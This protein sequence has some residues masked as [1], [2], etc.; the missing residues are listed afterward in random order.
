[1]TYGREF[2]RGYRAIVT[3]GAQ[4]IGSEI[5]RELVAVGCR[6]A[7]IDLQGEKAEA[8]ALEL[9]DGCIGIS[10]DITVATESVAAVDQVRN[11]MGGIDILINTAAPGRNRGVIGKIADSDWA[12]HQSVVL[13]GAANMVEATLN[14]LTASK[15]GAIV[16]ISSVLAGSVGLDQASVAYHVAKAGLNQFTRWLAVRCGP[17][18]VRVNAV[19]PGLVDRGVGQK[20]SDSLINRTIIETLVPVGRAAS[21]QEV[22]KAV[23]FLAS[24]A[25]SYITG[26]VITVDGGMGL[27]ETFG[28]GLSVYN[29]FARP[30]DL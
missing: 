23:I 26:E 12:L 20:I 27:R 4:G 13:G 14:D 6:V 3:G 29:A 9:G 21:G 5:V 10:A 18:G 11:A 7:I 1:M 28:S 17:V 25:A 8:L 30:S 2:L 16:N 22:A 24:D 15:R 19:A